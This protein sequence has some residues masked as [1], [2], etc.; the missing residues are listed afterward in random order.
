M[1]HKSINSTL[2]YRIAV[3]KSDFPYVM[4]DNETKTYVG[5]SIDILREFQNRLNFTYDIYE[6]DA[7]GPSAYDILYQEIINKNADILLHDSFNMHPLEDE[8]DFTNPVYEASGL[9]IL[10]YTPSF[11]LTHFTFLET[12]ETNVWF[13]IVGLY[14]FTSILLTIFNKWSPYS[15]K[16]NKTNVQ[17][18][19]RN[20]TFLESLWFCL[21]NLTPQG[22]NELP[23]NLS[24]RLIAIVWSLFGNL[25][26]TFFAANLA[27]FLTVPTLNVKIETVED[28]FYQQNIQYG[29]VENSTSYKYI[30][31]VT[32]VNDIFNK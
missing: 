30:E 12:F 5:Y 22:R 10:M 3:R 1:S 8:V 19:K 26:L 13:S 15:Y 11:S 29:V 6:I 27:N 25:V 7:K 21:I 20:F 16:N 18:T 14:F 28:L 23:E 17:G 2:H 9:S 24:G 31:Q 4:F 32:R